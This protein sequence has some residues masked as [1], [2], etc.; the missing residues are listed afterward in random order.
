M[1]VP[2]GLASG[3]PVPVLGAVS[4]VESAPPPPVVV[5]VPA[6]APADWWPKTEPA[7]S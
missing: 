7:T 6:S 1:S 3:L 2:P 4:W 5:L